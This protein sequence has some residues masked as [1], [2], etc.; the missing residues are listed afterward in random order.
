M[1]RPILQSF[2]SLAALA[3]TAAP[4]YA[5]SS[6]VYLEDMTW[7]EVRE[8]MQ[9]GATVAIV[10]TGG[11]EQNGPQMVIGKHNI[12]VHYTAGEIAKR[13]GNAMVAP[14]ISYVPEGRISPPEGHMQF[15]GTMAVR[16]E[17]FAMMLEDAATSLKQH[18]FRL[19]CFIG[20]HGGNQEVQAQV[21]DKLTAQWQS[22]GVRVLQVGDYYANNGQDR[23]VQSTGIKVQNPGAHS[24][25]EDTSEL[26]AI[27]SQG[28]RAGLRAYHTERDYTTT[29]AM[30]DSTQASADSGRKLLSLKIEAAVNQISNV[31][32]RSQ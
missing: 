17:T 12:I 4:V 27:D 1:M 2:L 32:S 22:S 20:D 31:I 19:I 21:A 26:M 7:M 3:V 30:G 13:L 9:N 25:L 6:A 15:P 14:V 24:G 23:W 5:A 18:G 8:R 11:T 10:P 29:G 16:P 28:V